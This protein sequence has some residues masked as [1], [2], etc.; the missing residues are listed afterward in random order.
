MPSRIKKYWYLILLIVSAVFILDIGGNEFLTSSLAPVDDVANE[1]ASTTMKNSIMA[2]GAAKALNSAISLL[3]SGMFSAGVV[4]SGSVSPG[5]VLEPF[6]L[7]VE[8]F[9][10]AMLVV[11]AIC[12]LI[13]IIFKV[14]VLWGGVNILGYGIAL[15]FFYF[16]LGKKYAILLRCGISIILIVMTIRIFIPLAFLVAD[17]TSKQVVN[18]M[19]NDNIS[20]LHRISLTLKPP[21][22]INGI[23]SYFKETKMDAIAHSLDGIFM[24]AVLIIAGFTAKLVLLPVLALWLMFGLVRLIFAEI[25]RIDTQSL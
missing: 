3:K 17:T 13:V 8:Q 9:S 22:D 18:T 6:Y 12:S 10:T 21:A 19:I 16:L 4:V 24:S 23:I 5:A 1:Y 20:N 25:Q 15:I 2:F 7:T 14:G 11:S